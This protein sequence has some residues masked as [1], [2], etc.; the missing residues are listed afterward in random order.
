MTR[1]ERERRMPLVFEIHDGRTSRFFSY[2]RVLNERACGLRVIKQAMTELDAWRKTFG[3]LFE[4]LQFADW[5]ELIGLLDQVRGQRSQRSPTHSR[6]RKDSRYARDKFY[7][8]IAAIDE[9]RRRYE[10]LFEHLKYADG[11]KV[12]R[13]VDK[14]CHPEDGQVF[15]VWELDR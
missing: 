9:W 8:A 11:R 3:R 4:I 12:T 13:A 7:E 6:A 1:S 10:D 14:A 15:H 5:R 2:E